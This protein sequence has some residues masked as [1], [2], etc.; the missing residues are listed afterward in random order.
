ME[1]LLL[2]VMI[3][4]DTIITFKRLEGKQLHESWIRFKTLLIKC[5]THEI[6]DI[7]LLECFREVS[8]QKIGYW[9]TNLSV[10]VW[11]NN[12]MR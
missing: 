2:E 5:P 10:I 11:S 9:P 12:L 7:V 3:F 6:L 4:K 8:V 1:H